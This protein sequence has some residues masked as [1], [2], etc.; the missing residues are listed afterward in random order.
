MPRRVCSAEALPALE[1]PSAPARN[2]ACPAGVP[3]AAAAGSR[4]GT[5]VLSLIALG[6]RGTD[7]E[8]LSAVEISIAGLK[9]VGFDKEAQAIALEIAIEAGL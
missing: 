7:P 9:R 3:G 2:R 5:V 8:N 1:L 4:G 6:D